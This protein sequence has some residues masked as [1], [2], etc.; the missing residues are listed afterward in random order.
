VCNPEMSGGQ[1]LLIWSAKW[2][3]FFRI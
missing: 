3:N 1:D 2:I